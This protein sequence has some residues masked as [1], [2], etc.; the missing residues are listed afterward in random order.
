MAGRDGQLEGCWTCSTLQGVSTNLMSRQRRRGSAAVPSTQTVKPTSSSVVVRMVR[1]TSVDV[2]FA[3]RLKATAP[4][5]PESRE[6]WITAIHQTNWQPSCNYLR[7]AGESYPDNNRSHPEYMT[8]SWP[9][10]SPQKQTFRLL[11]SGDIILKARS[12]SGRNT[13]GRWWGSFE[14]QQDKGF[15][16]RNLLT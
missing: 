11:Y 10:S 16:Q 7:K 12:K 3:A 14:K 5:K 8:S 4:L 15:L 2:S 13:W 9:A 6:D 1:L